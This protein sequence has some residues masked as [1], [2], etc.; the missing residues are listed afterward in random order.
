MGCLFIDLVWHIVHYAHHEARSRD[1][2]EL[3]LLRNSIIHLELALRYAGWGQKFAP[4]DDWTRDACKA[5]VRSVGGKLPVGI[6]STG[7][8]Q[9]GLPEFQVDMPS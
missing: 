2:Q 9:V 5:R 1:L 4:H 8:L 6:G 7:T 3:G